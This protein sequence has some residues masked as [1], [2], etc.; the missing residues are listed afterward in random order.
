MG[1]EGFYIRRCVSPVEEICLG[2][3]REGSCKLNPVS[4]ESIAGF[5]VLPE[6]RAIS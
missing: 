3:K 2:I 5:L 6:F 1:Q 4:P